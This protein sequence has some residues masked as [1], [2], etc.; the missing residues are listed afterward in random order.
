MVEIFRS[1]HS[2]DLN[3]NDLV[4]YRSLTCRMEQLKAE[5]ATIKNYLMRFLG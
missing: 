4:F 5:D 2:S 3:V 1:S